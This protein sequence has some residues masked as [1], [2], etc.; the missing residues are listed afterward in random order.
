MQR[1]AEARAGMDRDV[2]TAM[3]RDTV[4]YHTVDADADSVGPGSDRDRAQIFPD[5]QIQISLNTRDPTRTR[6][7]PMACSEH[8]LCSTTP[9]H[10]SSSR[11]L[12]SH[13]FK[14]RL[15]STNPRPPTLLPP[16]ASICVQLFAQLFAQLFTQ[17]FTQPSGDSREE[18]WRLPCACNMYTCVLHVRVPPPAPALC[19]VTCACCVFACLS[20]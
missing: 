12:L 3:D 6:G 17:L 13:Q 7:V 2:S 10:T 16:S 4:I 14:R 19:R 1:A 20:R 8:Q 11:A 9:R 18:R 5:I 15:R